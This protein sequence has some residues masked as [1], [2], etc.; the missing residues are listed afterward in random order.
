[1]LLLHQCHLSD[2]LNRFERIDERLADGKWQVAARLHVNAVGLS[3]GRLISQ[4]HTRSGG[5]CCTTA[6]SSCTL[7]SPSM[8]RDRLLMTLASVEATSGNP[9]TLPKRYSSLC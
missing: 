3:T 6:V 9:A 4:A 2:P 1:M 8:D 7:T 5:P